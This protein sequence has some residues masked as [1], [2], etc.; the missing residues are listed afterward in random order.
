VSRYLKGRERGGG[1]RKN[2]RENEEGRA[3]MREE[4]RKEEKETHLSSKC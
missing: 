1:E 4:G 2:R 3:G